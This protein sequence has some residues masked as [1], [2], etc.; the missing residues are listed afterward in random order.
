VGFGFG[1]GGPDLLCRIDWYRQLSPAIPEVWLSSDPVGELIAF[2]NGVAFGILDGGYVTQKDLGIY[3]FPLSMIDLKTGVD[4]KVVLHVPYQGEFP[5]PESNFSQSTSV[6]EKEIIETR[7]PYLLAITR[8]EIE[9]KYLRI[10][11]GM[12]NCARNLEFEI[13]ELLGD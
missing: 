3:H 11:L 6:D 5:I 10:T 9:G 12:E 4:R 13:D 8:L 7:G 2:G 1:P